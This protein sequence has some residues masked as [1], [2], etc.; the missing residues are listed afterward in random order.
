MRSHRVIYAALIGN[1]LVAVT[2]TVAAAITGSSAMLSEAVHSAVDTSNELLLLYGIS[3]SRRP[4]HPDHPLGHGR[5]LYFWSFIV[6]LL[7]F[8]L[9]AGISMYEGIIH[10]RHP[11]PITHPLVNY[12]VLAFASLFEGWTWLIA[13]R[14]FRAAQGSRR[15][16]EAFKRSKDPPSFMILF[17]DSA[18]LIGILIAAAGTFAATRLGFPVADGIASILIGLVLAGISVLLARES[19]SLLIG[20]RANPELTEGIL[21]IA[22]QASGVAEVSVAMT[23]QLAPDQIV[24]ALSF[25][26]PDDWRASEVVERVR[27]IEHAV[28]TAFPEVVDLFIK[29]RA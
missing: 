3:R 15:F 27:K 2:K 19:K 26:F 12:V 1:L 14:Q 6:A 13:L 4:P 28:Q 11:E 8:A 24:V 29:P 10:I 20:E 9:G 5:E 18:A 17:E 22:R 25:R 23:V 21:R 16:W 7:I